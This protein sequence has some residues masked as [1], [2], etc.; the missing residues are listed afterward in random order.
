[1]I[2]KFALLR[3]YYY[4]CGKIHEPVWRKGGWRLGAGRATGGLGQV[5]ILEAW[6]R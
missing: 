4:V 1:M 6:D 5:G 3:I 2:F